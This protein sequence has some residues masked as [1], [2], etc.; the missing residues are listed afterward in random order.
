MKR[1]KRALILVDHGS[2][3]KEANDTIV[4]VANMVRQNGKCDFDIVKYAHMELAE[5]TISEAFDACVAEGAEEIV[6]HPYFL[7]PGRHSS[8][9]IPSMVEDVAKKH[10]HV[11]YRV[12]EPLGLHQKIIEVILERALE[13]NIE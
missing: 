11:S 5:P 10:A 13:A 2:V 4:E 8:M 3:I 12:T 1:K 9:D 7:V 6:V